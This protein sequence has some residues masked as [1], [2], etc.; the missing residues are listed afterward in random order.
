[1]VTST[2]HLLLNGE[3]MGMAGVPPKQSPHADSIRAQLALA[4]SRSDCVTPIP[5]PRLSS[6]PM[7]CRTLGAW[8]SLAKRRDD[9]GSIGGWS[10]Y[11][12]K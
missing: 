6:S 11:A 10:P 2:Y 3:M 9:D 8:L 1:M 4:D 5:S 12:G 7:P